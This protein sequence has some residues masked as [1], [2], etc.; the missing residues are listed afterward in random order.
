MSKFS[1]LLRATL[2]GAVSVS[3][4]QMARLEQHY[5]LLERWNRTLNLTAIRTMEDAVVRHYAE[6][7]FLAERI[8]KLGESCSAADIGSGAGF[9][10]FPVAVMLPGWTVALVES[11]Q[12]KAVFLRESTRDLPSV[13]VITGRFEDASGRFDVGVSRAVAWRDLKKTV[14]SRVRYI[15]LLAAAADTPDILSSP[16]VAWDAPILLPWNSETTILLGNLGRNDRLL[17]RL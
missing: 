6:S 2:D 7:V 4:D 3:D 13:S 9:P 5:I 10:G 17:A 1:E 8:R 12:R 16:G 11:H 14:V 15:G